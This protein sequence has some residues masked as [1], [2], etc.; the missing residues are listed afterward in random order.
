MADYF[1]LHDLVPT[2][3]PEQNRRRQQKYVHFDNASGKQTLINGVTDYRKSWIVYSATKNVALL[4]TSK[5]E[6]TSMVLLMMRALHRL[7]SLERRLPV[8]SASAR[9]VAR[10]AISKPTKSADP[11]FLDDFHYL[12]YVSLLYDS[13]NR[14]DTFFT[15]LMAKTPA[16]SSDYPLGSVRC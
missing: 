5:R 10:L 9:I 3:D 2:D 6:S 1:R 13:I 12:F 8:H 16:D 7:P 11:H 15:A 4:G 14:N